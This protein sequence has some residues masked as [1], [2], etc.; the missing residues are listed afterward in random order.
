MKKLFVLTMIL[1]CASL[2]ASCNDQAGTNT[3]NKPANAANNTSANSATAS[4]DNSAE[5]KKLMADLGNA[6]AKN[7]ADAAAKFYADD[8]HLITPSGVDQSKADRIADMK[9]GKSKFESFEY[10]NVNVRSYGDIAIA[11]STVNAKGVLSGAPTSNAIATVVWHKEKDGW[12][13]V[14]GQATTISAGAAPTKPSETNSGAN[15]NSKPATANAN[16]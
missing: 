9:S 6:L 2:L 14:L 16:K 5:I 10:T 1:I 11:T 7:D 13:A 12:K 15:S 4:T 8:Y 3:A